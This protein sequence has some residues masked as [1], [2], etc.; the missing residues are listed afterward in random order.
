MF[1][2]YP[3]QPS[4]NGLIAIKNER[5]GLTRAQRAHAA[6]RSCGKLKNAQV[7]FSHQGQSHLMKR[8]HAAMKGSGDT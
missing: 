8:C 1:D 2:V 7:V 6:I 4:L 5:L 3:F